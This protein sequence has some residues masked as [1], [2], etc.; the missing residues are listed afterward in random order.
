MLFRGEFKAREKW[1]RYRSGS[2]LV[3]PW[4][5]EEVMSCTHKIVT[6]VNVYSSM[7]DSQYLVFIF[8]LMEITFAKS[9]VSDSF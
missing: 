2:V 1:D 5:K 4:P 3:C 7:R 8:H 9:T 6:Q